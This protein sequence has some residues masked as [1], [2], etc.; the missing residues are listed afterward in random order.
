MPAEPAARPKVRLCAAP[1]RAGQ[2]VQA[3]RVA[4]QA[5]QVVRA[6]AQ[7]RRCFQ[8]SGRRYKVRLQKEAQ[9]ELL[10]EAWVEPPDLLSEQHDNARARKT[11]R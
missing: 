6:A 11:I 2:P 5:R 9:N 7:Q 10:S 3:M 4:R 1:R 8:R